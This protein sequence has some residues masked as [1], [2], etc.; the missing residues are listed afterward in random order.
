MNLGR[1]LDLGG[2]TF[3][4]LS[5]GILAI[6]S[7]LANGIISN[8]VDIIPKRFLIGLEVAVCQMPNFVDGYNN[9][10]IFIQ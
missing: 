7:I 10:P 2:K 1:E 8:F 3:S 5:S 4:L 9:S 6:L